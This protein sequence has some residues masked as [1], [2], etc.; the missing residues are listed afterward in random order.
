LG[1][2]GY[3]TSSFSFSA[4]E[5]FSPLLF[6]FFH[7]LCCPLQEPNF[8][9]KF[10]A[11]FDSHSQARVHD[12]RGGHE[13]SL[14][15]TL[16]FLKVCEGHAMP[17][18]SN[19]LY[20]FGRFRLDGLKRT[21]TRGTE[22]VPLTPKALETLLVL[23]QNSERVVPKDELMKAVWPDSYVEENNLS[24]NIL[25][26]RRVL[27]DSP[28][29]RYIVTVPGRGYQFVEKVIVA[30][31]DISAIEGRKISI[32]VQDN[33][34]RDSRATP[35]KHVG[36]WLGAMAI[37]GL[38]VVTL[39][40]SLPFLARFYNNRGVVHQQTGDI[41][42]AIQDYKWALRFSP[43]YTEAHYNLGDVYEEI[44]D[45][46][47]AVE[48][49]Q[50][51]ID[52]DP[53]FYAAYNNLARLY[54]M[55]RR[56]FGAALVLLDRALSL[57]PQEAPVRYTL[58]KNYGWANLGLGQLGQ[59]ERNLRLAESLDPRRGSAHCLLAN[60]LEG[61]ER[62]ADAIPEWESCLAYSNQPEVEPEWRNAAQEHLRPAQEH[63][64]G[65]LK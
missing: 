55:R 53:K 40:S 65:G 33:L 37:T 7:W 46:D 30:V 64:T 48:Q 29:S 4:V 9:G 18:A 43:A 10:L 56:D 21:L 25:T 32:A 12:V 15:G 62:A 39:A 27:G 54:I 60:V 50:R 34:E 38:L 47:K 14:E 19:E 23:V 49:Y 36:R 58:Y 35:I 24:Q 5:S 13:K 2:I 28:R 41:R 42:A 1:V 44:P 57:Q 52:V 6:S 3:L 45:Y 59:A 31:Q 16:E 20:E 26:L 51:A 17:N 8:G 63:L 22:L 11:R 61:Q